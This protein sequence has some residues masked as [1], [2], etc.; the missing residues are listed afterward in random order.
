MAATVCSF[1][2]QHPLEK[3]VKDNC[4]HQ[5]EGSALS[6]HPEV[7]LPASALCFWRLRLPFSCFFL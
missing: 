5:V 1:P 7:L 2:A 4:S 6:K 3:A